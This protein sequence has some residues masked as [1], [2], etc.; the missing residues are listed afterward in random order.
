MHWIYEL[1]EASGDK[2]MLWPDAASTGKNSDAVFK[3]EE[4]LRRYNKYS[5][6]G[7]LS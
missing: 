4:S 3:L 2:E 6:E 5:A 1:G 7:N